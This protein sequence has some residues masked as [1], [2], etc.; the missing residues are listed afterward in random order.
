MSTEHSARHDVRQVERTH[1]PRVGRAIFSIRAPI[2]M[3]ISGAQPRLQ[4][5][6]AT[7]R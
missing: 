4:V 6:A 3:K 1:L 7:S 5:S 2:T